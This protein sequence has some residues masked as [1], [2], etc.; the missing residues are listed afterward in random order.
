VLEFVGRGRRDILPAADIDDAD[1]RRRRQ[2][3]ACRDARGDQRALRSGIDHEVVGTPPADRHRD[4]QPIVAVRPA[5]DRLERLGKAQ[6]EAA[7]D[8]VHLD[9]DTHHGTSKIFFASAKARGLHLRFGG[10]AVVTS[11]F[12]MAPLTA[13]LLVFFYGRLRKRGIEP[14]DATWLTLLLG[15]GTPLFFRAGHLNHNLFAMAAAFLSFCL[16]WRRRDGERSVATSAAAGLLAGATLAIDY[17]GVVLVPCLFLYHWRSAPR[18]PGAGSRWRHAAA[19]VGGSVPPVLFLLWSQWSMFGNPFLPG[20]AWMPDNR[21]SGRGVRGISWPTLALLRDNLFHPAYGIFTYGPLLA[22][23][24]LPAP[25]ARRPILGDEERRFV[26]LLFAVVLV[27]CASNQYSHLQFGTGFRYLAPVLP[28]LFLAACD[29]LLALSATWRLLV[30]V[31]AFAHSWVLAAVREPV[32]L[33]WRSVLEGG[34][35]LPWLNVLRR[36]R[37]DDGSLIFASWL[38][39]LLLAGLALAAWGTW[40]L[41]PRMLRSARTAA[42]AE[43]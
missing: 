16:S 22:L 12:F 29:R 14:S 36:T 13:A 20:Q 43:H 30:S 34:P 15:Y 2:G 31:L 8:D 35:Q 42:D 23:G 24:L 6:V 33:S 3:E 26:W 38:P 40:S 28:F 39:L 11:V 1:S 7:G 27:F 17:I 41:P 32:P 18:A 4:G 9:Y 21:F 37:P 25:R 10:M 5:L 19:F